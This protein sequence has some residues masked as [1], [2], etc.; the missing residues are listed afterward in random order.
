VLGHVFPIYHRFVGGKGVATAAG[1]LCAI[2]PWL[3]AGTVATWLIIAGFFRISSLAALVAATAAPVFT[4]MLYD[5]T[6]P[7]FFAVLAIS[8]LL[9]LRHR[10]N[11]AKLL[12]GT[13]DRIGQRTSP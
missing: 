12:A 13:E 2:D 11:I 6:H 5:L 4:A 3:G 1:A 9:V 10:S 8:V 7:Y